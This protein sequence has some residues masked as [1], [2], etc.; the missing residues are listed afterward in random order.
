ML[1]SHINF[2]SEFLKGL[3][4]PHLIISHLRQKSSPRQTPKWQKP[5]GL[6]NNTL[7]QNQLAG[8][9]AFAVRRWF[10]ARTEAISASLLCKLHPKSS[11]WYSSKIGPPNCIQHL[12]HIMMLHSKSSLIQKFYKTNKYVK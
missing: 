4:F 6:E 7:D 1:E 11:K 3:T 2:H 9:A 8:F 12:F 10:A 5:A